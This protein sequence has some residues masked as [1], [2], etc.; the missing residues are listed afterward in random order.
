M[1]LISGYCIGGINKKWIFITCI[2]IGLSES[3]L[4]QQHDFFIKESEYKLELESIS[5]LV[6]SKKDL[7]AINGNDN[8]QQLY[9]AHRKGWTCS[10]SLITDLS[11]INNIQKKVVVIFFLISTVVTNQ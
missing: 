7:I 1:A 11:F 4:N 6:S 3:I 9:L 8:P 2:I 5:D 10:D